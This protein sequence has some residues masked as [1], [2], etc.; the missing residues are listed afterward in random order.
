MPSHKR[1]HKHRTH[2]TD[3][4]GDESTPLS[5]VFK[6]GIIGPNLTKLVSD[7]RDLMKPYT[8]SELKERPSNK[9]KDFVHV[10]APLGVTHFLIVSSGEQHSRL[11]IARVPQGPTFHFNIEQYSLMEDIRRVQKNPHAT[12]SDYQHPP[13]VVLNNFDQSRPEHA[14]MTTLFQKMFPAVVLDRIELDHCKRVMLVNYCADDDTVHIRQYAIT[15]K[16]QL[17]SGTIESLSKG[18]MMDLS[19]FDS[20]EDA[21]KGTKASQSEH[22]F[23][24]GKSSVGLVELGPRLDIRLGKIEAGFHEGHVLYALRDQADDDEDEEVEVEQEKKSKKEH[25][26]KKEKKE[27]RAKGDKKER[28]HEKKEHGAVKRKAPGV[29][30]LKRPTD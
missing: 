25:K 12:S 17:T 6:R 8:A 22:S 30:V 15:L 7:L 14:L 20:I 19:K 28:K 9:L 29:G 26:D 21:V 27:K 10:A 13:L 16:P 2:I 3:D 11:R 4:V 23:T 18:K 24:K 1:R 5:F